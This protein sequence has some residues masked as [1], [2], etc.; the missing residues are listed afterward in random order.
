MK[1]ALL[2]PLAASCFLA[3][4]SMGY[5]SELLFRSVDPRRPFL[6]QKLVDL[7]LPLELPSSRTRALQTLVLVQLGV[8][9]ALALR[10][11]RQAP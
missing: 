5:F 9:L 7:P 6:S 4:W 10:S 1:A 3:G 8:L 11:L 2:L